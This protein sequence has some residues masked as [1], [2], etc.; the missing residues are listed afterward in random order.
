[1]ERS[2]LSAPA[3][4]GVTLVRAEPPKPTYVTA[5]NGQP[6]QCFPPNVPTYNPIW[7]NQHE[8]YL[9]SRGWEKDGDRVGL[10]TYRDPKGSKLQGELKVVAELPNK[11]DDLHPTITVRQMHLPPATYSF[12]LEEAVD[13]QRR[14]DA[15]GDNGPTPLE[16]LDEVEKRCNDLQRDLEQTKARIKILLTTPQLTYEG[17]KLGLRELVGMS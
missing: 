9:A 12:T 14:R 10:P 5:A 3:D 6:Q 13:I 17:M 4:E 7:L 1:M 11:G 15:H 16:R 2:T 8:E